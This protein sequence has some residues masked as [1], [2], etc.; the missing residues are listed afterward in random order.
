MA[1]VTL[2]GLVWAPFL[3]TEFF[4]RLNE[5]NYVVHLALAAGSSLEQS[6]AIGNRVTAELRKIPYIQ[7]VEQRSGKSALAGDVLGPQYS[8]FLIR[9]KP[10]TPGH[11][12][13]FRAAMAE[14][15]KKFPGVLL[16]YNTVLS[17]RINETISGSGA[18]VAV[19]VIGNHF[20][21]IEQASAMLVA[22]LK[23][24]PGARSVAPQTPWNA[25]E[26]QVRLR[27]KQLQRWGLSPMA[28]LEYV[29]LLIRGR[30]A[31]HIYHGTRVWPVV[32]TMTPQLAH[33]I[34]MIRDVPIR[35]PDGTWIPLSDVARVY[36]GRGFYRISHIKGQ[37]AQMISI[38][39]AGVT[40]GQYVHAAQQAI[41]KLHLSAGVVVNF[42]GSAAAAAKGR[43]DLLVHSSIALLGIL[44][45]LFIVLKYVN[46]VILLLLNL[47]L[48][49]VGGV[50]AAWISGGVLSLGALVGF[51]TLFG[52]TLRNS[53]M[54][55]SI[56]S[57]LS[58]AREKHGMF[59]PLLMAR[60]IAC[61]QY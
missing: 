2:A 39:L 27:R 10:L 24:V 15:I 1:L 5:R 29:H 51:I 12:R 21:T 35:T 13:R 45:L 20:A 14:L 26:I 11:A 4:P 42:T 54:L 32:V 55:M 7:E 60:L 3:K 22:A 50:A 37:R 59:K 6:I 44:L 23:K 48:A 61:R 53:I 25:P 18:P 17:E 30:R 16:Y 33:R 56:I 34:S 38:H 40:A 43:H 57:I 31:G 28:V 46:N 41:A 49:L 58:R 36:E 52:I 47:P 8:E 9:V 19:Q